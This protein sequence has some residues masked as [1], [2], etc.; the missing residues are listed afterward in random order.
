VIVDV[1]TI[2]DDECAIKDESDAEARS[3]AARPPRSMGRFNRGTALRPGVYR[4][5][6]AKTI[7]IA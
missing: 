6:H 7:I 4:D 3:M 1:I 2:N 5:S